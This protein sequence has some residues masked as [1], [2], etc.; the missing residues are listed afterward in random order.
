MANCILIYICKMMK[1]IEEH[2]FSIKCLYSYLR[3]NVFTVYAFRPI[4]RKIFQSF[5]FALIGHQI[6][7]TSRRWK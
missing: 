2:T 1:H 5:L 6:I 3:E 4:F 7:L